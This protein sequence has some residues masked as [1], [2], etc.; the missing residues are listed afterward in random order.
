VEG[1]ARSRGKKGGV[2]GGGNGGSLWH[3]IVRLNGRGKARLGIQFTLR[4]GK[5]TLT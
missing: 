5:G 4:I 1:D 3:I 2:Y